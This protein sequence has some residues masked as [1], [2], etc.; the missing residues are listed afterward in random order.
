MK[1]VYLTVVIF[2]F[3]CS[4]IDLEDDVPS[5]LECKID[6]IRQ[7]NAC[8]KSNSVDEYLFQG[9]T[10]FTFSPNCGNDMLATVIDSNC[11]EI[12]ALGGI[13]GNFIV[14][15]ESFSNAVFVRNVWKN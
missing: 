13:A 7:I 8:E 9:K 5:C 4:K 14:N 10:V 1:V 2:F 11:K 15:G 6:E 12:G 3:G